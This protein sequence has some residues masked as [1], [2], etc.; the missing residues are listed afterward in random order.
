MLYDLLHQ[1]FPCD[2]VDLKCHPTRPL[3]AFLCSDPGSLQ[4]WDYSVQLLM[5]LRDFT[6]Q[7]DSE[8]VTSPQDAKQVRSLKSLAHAKAG[9]TEAK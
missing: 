6:S 8:Q 9:N 7:K 2:V 3:V 4:I 1:G 5:T